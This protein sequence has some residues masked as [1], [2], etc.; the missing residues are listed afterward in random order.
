MHA[1]AKKHNFKNCA[2]LHYLTSAS[3][4]RL[5]EWLLF[6]WLPVMWRSSRG[7]PV[8][9]TGFFSLRFQEAQ[10]WLDR[11][12][13]CQSEEYG[14]IITALSKPWL[15]FCCFYGSNFALYTVKWWCS[16]EKHC[17]QV[18]EPVIDSHVKR[19]LASEV[20]C[21]PLSFKHRA[22]L[23]KGGDSQQWQED[24]HGC[25]LSLSCLQLPAAKFLICKIRGGA[26]SWNAD[27]EHEN[28]I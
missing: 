15:W 2:H 28:V 19:W 7:S 12:M 6:L 1:C 27:V 17:D 5:M 14:S 25:A 8:T 26:L 16:Y 4:Q 22:G 11:I 9:W 24:Q 20:C 10:T 18:K 3:W 21:M 13:T 23:K